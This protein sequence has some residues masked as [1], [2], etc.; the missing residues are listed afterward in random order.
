MRIE[1]RLTVRGTT[2]PIT[3]SAEVAVDDADSATL[4]TEFS[5]DRTEFGLS[6]NQMGM[7]RG[8]ATVIATLRFTRVAA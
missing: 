2:R 5:V 4:T 8:P 6:W 7:L 1:G 3:L